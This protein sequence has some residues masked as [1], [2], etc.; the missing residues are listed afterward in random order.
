MFDRKL[1]SKRVRLKYGLRK[2]K[3]SK[4]TFYRKL[5]TM[6]NAPEQKYECDGTVS[7]DRTEVD[8]FVEALNAERDKT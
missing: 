4:A 7:F 5:A 8:R 2:A 3:C 6:P 1:K